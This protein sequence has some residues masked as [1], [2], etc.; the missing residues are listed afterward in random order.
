MKFRIRELIKHGESTYYPERKIL[1]WWSGY[2]HGH[3]DFSDDVYF[4]VIGEAK[5][6]IIR[7]SDKTKVIYHYYDPLKKTEE[8][9]I[10]P[11]YI[12]R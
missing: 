7:K 3:P 2:S 10:E 8:P 12:T 9:T 1:W 11:Q 6:F 5:K 4:K